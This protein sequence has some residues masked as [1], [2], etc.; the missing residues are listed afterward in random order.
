MSKPTQ[1]NTLVFCCVGFFYLFDSGVEEEIHHVYEP[2]CLVYRRVDSQ[3]GPIEGVERLG[4]DVVS[5]TVLMA[6]AKHD[7]TSWNGMIERLTCQEH[8]CG[9]PRAM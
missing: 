3:P 6:D 4:H 1:S 2:F 5:G 9:P 7:S 8:V